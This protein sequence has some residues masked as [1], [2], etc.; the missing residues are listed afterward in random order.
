M[1]ESNP[2]AIPP[3]HSS[4]FTAAE[5][6]EHLQAS[7]KR[8]SKTIKASKE[9]LTRNSSSDAEC[10]DSGERK[11][12]YKIRSS[13]GLDKEGRSSTYRE[14]FAKQ[15]ERLTYEKFPTKES[16]RWFMHFFTRSPNGL[17]VTGG[18]RDTSVQGN[19]RESLIKVQNA[20]HPNFAEE[21]SHWCPIT[22][23]WLHEKLT[24]AAH[25]FPWKYGQETMTR[26]FETE[27]EHEMF[28]VQN[29]LLMSTMA[30]AAIDK[31]LFVI[32]PFANDESEA[33]V[34]EWHK[35]NPKRYKLRV[36]DKADKMMEGNIPDPKITWTD[37]DGSELQFRSD[38]RPR[39]R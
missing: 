2:P 31:G 4:E 15:A 22:C 21:K 23:S 25:I 19:F 1:D 35:S 14:I 10:E 18:R 26:I 8:L 27:A 28:S 3:R 17:A 20:K 38:H 11:T 12:W 34:K 9:K 24:T 16:R 13:Q 36:L 6:I 32:V 5:S 30:E 7:K 29:G 33:E 39:A 37:L